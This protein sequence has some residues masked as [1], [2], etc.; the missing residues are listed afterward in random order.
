MK[1]R[2][3]MSPREM[4]REAADHLQ[5]ALGLLDCAEAPAHIGAHV[6]LAIHQLEDS[7][8]GCFGNPA[9]LN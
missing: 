5:S 9:I 8:D 2:S 6:D 3:E 4:L 1:A 7:I